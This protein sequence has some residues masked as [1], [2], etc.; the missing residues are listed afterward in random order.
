VQVDVLA[1]RDRVPEP[2]RL[3]LRLG[4]ARAA[5]GQ[6]LGVAFRL[7]AAV[8][9]AVQSERGRRRGDFPLRTV[10]LA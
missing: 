6:R 7:A 3:R 2:C 4:K 1:R 9:P 5:G 8:L 10:S